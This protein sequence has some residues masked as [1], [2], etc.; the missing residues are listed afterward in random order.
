MAAQP[1]LGLQMPNVTQNTA[2][3]NVPRPAFQNQ[4]PGTF[5]FAQARKLQMASK[6]RPKSVASAPSQLLQL[7][8]ITLKRSGRHNNKDKISDLHGLVHQQTQELESL[9]EQN[10][11]LKLRAGVLEEMLA[12][13]E[14]E[15]K[16][17]RSFG[18]ARHASDAWKPEVQRNEVH[19]A[20]GQPI[21]SLGLTGESIK[22]LSPESFANLWRDFV[23]E[24][25]RLLLLIDNPSSPDPA[26][27]ETLNKLSGTMAALCQAVACLNV[28]AVLHIVMRNF[29][30][31]HQPEIP[32]PSY[33]KQVLYSL[34]LS[35]DQ[36]EELRTLYE[37]YMKTSDKL[38][39]EN[40]RLKAQLQEVLAGIST[41]PS[42]DMAG[43]GGVEQEELVVQLDCN[44]IRL[45]TVKSMLWC[46]VF[47]RLTGVQF[48]KTAMY[49]YPYFPTP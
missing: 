4:I 34:S 29:E 41:E 6:V 23:R 20:E 49:S 19:V 18:P 8:P 31:N 38:W 10:S 32:A 27:V 17:L 22:N 33:W 12:Q 5:N 3:P 2:A 15:L 35:P 11:K 47:T 39:D 37:V 24:A 43:V 28:P 9:L 25:T 26:A 42:L 46:N 36:L 7:K 45:H 30:T 21:E 14:S 16:I 40:C 1:S 13:R 44:L 48:A